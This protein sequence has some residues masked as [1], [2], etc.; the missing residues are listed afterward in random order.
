MSFLIEKIE[1]FESAPPPQI[2]ETN[3]YCYLPLNKQRNKILG[4]NIVLA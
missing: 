2:G 3:F 4:K 1:I